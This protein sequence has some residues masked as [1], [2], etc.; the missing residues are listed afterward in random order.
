MEPLS[1]ITNSHNMTIQSKSSVFK[2]KFLF[3]VVSGPYFLLKPKN[4]K[5]SKVII[6]RE[7]AMKLE[8]E[9]LLKN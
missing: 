8:Y 7:E 4:H 3:S 1:F 2:S 9:P 6:D 5:D